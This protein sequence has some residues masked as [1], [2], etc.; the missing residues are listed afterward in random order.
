L[1]SHS[2]KRLTYIRRCR[3]GNRVERNHLSQLAQTTRDLG[4]VSF[5]GQGHTDTVVRHNC[6]RD[7]I[8]MDIDDSGRLMRPFFSWG[9]YL[10]NYA[11]G[12]RVESHMLNGNVLGACPLSLSSSYRTDRCSWDRRCLHPRRFIQCDR[13]QYSLPLLQRQHAGA[14]ALRP[15]ALYSPVYHAIRHTN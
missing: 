4:G 10:D 3:Y 11:T 13:Q 5:I 6:V 15:C 2:I 7:V 9:V 8:G 14:R 12:F 1:H